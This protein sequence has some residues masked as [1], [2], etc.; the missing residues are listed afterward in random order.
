MVKICA[1]ASGSNGNC[2]YIGNENEA[3]IIDIG[4]SNRQLSQRLTEAGLSIRKIKAVFITHEHTDHVKGLRVVADKNS[5]DAYCTK[6]THDKTRPDYR[7]NRINYFIP[8]DTISI[9]D[10]K[11]HSFD[12]QHDAIEPVSFRVE[13]D[14]INIAVLTDVGIVSNEIKNQLSLCN[15]AFLESNYEHDLLINGNYPTFLKNRVASDFGHL[16]NT[17]AFELIDSLKDSHL[18]TVFLSHISSDNNRIDL[19]LN[20]FKTLESTHCIEPTS[21]HGISKVIELS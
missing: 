11:V 12:K 5:I 17:Q 13:I 7:A 15:A 20:S 16:S 8:G 6:K 2:Y 9:G 21:R 4:I 18:K 14:G 1:L 3:V 10:I 19:A